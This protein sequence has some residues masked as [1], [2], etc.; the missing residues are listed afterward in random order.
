MELAAR[1]KIRLCIWCDG[2]LGVFEYQEPG[3]NPKLLKHAGA[4]RGYIQIPKL[5]ITPRDGESQFEQVVIV[6][7]I[8]PPQGEGLPVVNYPQFLGFIG[9]HEAILNMGS[10]GS[11]GCLSIWC[12]IAH[13]I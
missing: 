9:H 1:G 5:A 12:S 3:N 8:P 13:H 6:E 4:V 11:T 10:T 7:E 2:L